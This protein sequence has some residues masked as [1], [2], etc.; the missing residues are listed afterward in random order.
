MYG[1]PE[2]T[3]Q[4][5]KKTFRLIN[6]LYSIHPDIYIF[7]PQIYRPYPGSTLY[8]VCVEK[9]FP[10]KRSLEDW[11]VKHDRVLGYV[12]LDDYKWVKNAN[13][14]P[15]I[16]FYGKFAYMGQLKASGIIMR[17]TQH[18]LSIIAKYRFEN[19]CYTLPIEYLLFT[20]LKPYLQLWTWKSKQHSENS[21]ALSAGHTGKS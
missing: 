9:G 12:E 8:D 18:L 15:Y 17:A 6:K 19:D 7:G 14:L 1:L 3:S 16:G 5:I 13:V 21:I 20:K 4:D 2:E 11:D 10:E